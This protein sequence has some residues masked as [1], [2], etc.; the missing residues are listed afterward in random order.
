MLEYHPREQ[1]VNDFTIIRK[2]GLYHL[3]HISGKRTNAGPGLTDEMRQGHAV[4]K[5]LIHW[6]EKPYVTKVGGACSCVR[7]GDRYAIISNVNHICWSKDLNEW[8]EPEPLVFDFAKNTRYYET[9]WDMAE[10]R[11]NSH[12]DPNIVW[13]PEKKCFVMFFCSRVS[14][15]EMFTR[16][17]VG[18]AESA[19]LVHWKLQKPVLGPGDHLFPESPHVIDLDGKYHLFFTV[20]PENGLRHAVA[21]RL[22]GP[23][24]EVERMDVLP[25]YVT[26]SEAVKT[27]DGWLFLGRLEDRSQ[28][29]NQARMVPRALCLPLR[30]VAGAGD[31]IL[32]QA[33]DCLAAL[34]GKSLFD[35][36]CQPLQSCWQV[37]SGDW[38]INTSPALAPN[39]HETIPA[40]SLYGSSGQAPALVMLD[41][42]VRNFDLEFEF[43]L[44]T[45]NGF[46]GQYRGGF[47]CDGVRFQVDAWNKA[48]F[49]QDHT[50]DILAFKALPFFKCDRYYRVRLFRCDG[51]TQL[52]FDDE[53]LMYLPAYGNGSHRIEFHVDHSDVI[54]R[55][56]R[57]WPL[58]VDDNRGFALDNPQ[59][60]TM[61][62][63]YS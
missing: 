29:C 15:G 41:R 35:S 16:G 7:F 32:F 37:Q 48:V 54:V 38:R 21:E 20:S 10:A 61:N 30:V 47:G 58:Q 59:G 31:R 40:N 36:A 42:P 46:D 50:G 60:A 26:A 28:A 33:H 2:G 56:L 53:L 24:T 18:L 11:Y 14:Y 57:L 49:C 17:C 1:Y 52:F 34:R 3:F 19:D 39:R 27:D 51:I 45:F 5:D 43:Q 44:P 62:G 23:Y 6:Q 55:N 9:G 25:A 22:R 12:R 8:S 4:S 13:D 63:I